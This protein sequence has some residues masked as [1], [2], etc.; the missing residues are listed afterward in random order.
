MKLTAWL[1]WEE[2]DILL[3][4]TYGWRTF[5]RGAQLHRHGDRHGDEFILSVACIFHLEATN[6]EEPWKLEVKRKGTT[7][8][9]TIETRPGDLLLYESATLEH[10]RHGPLKG[11]QVV[12]GL[13]HM[14]PKKW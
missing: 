10:G 12:N 6:M 2:G 9:H 5:K 8:L 1:G 7:P 14:R 4:R 11:E 3:T 13:V